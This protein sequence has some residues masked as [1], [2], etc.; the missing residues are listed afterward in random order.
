MAPE[1]V[2]SAR[3]VDRRADVW[4][5]G[6]CLYEMA[7]GQ[8]PFRADNLLDLGAKIVHEPEADVQSIRPDMPA[9]LA[10]IIHRCLQKKPDHRYADAGALAAALEEYAHRPA[11]DPRL[12]QHPFGHSGATAPFAGAPTSAPIPMNAP[13]PYGPAPF[14][15]PSSTRV[16]VDAPRS[17]PARA[18]D[19]GG[20]HGTG[21]AWGE[22]RPKAPSRVVPIVLAVF[23]LVALVGLVLVG[24]VF[25]RGKPSNEPPALAA[26]APPAAP[27]AAPPPATS[28]ETPPAEPPV[29]ASVIASATATTAPIAAAPLAPA[30][31]ASATHTRPAAAPVPPRPSASPSPSPR[32]A[33]SQR[34]FD[35]L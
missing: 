16:L 1:Q 3:T 9:E 32:P 26:S 31:I 8:A 29:I 4:S 21:I 25:V 10:A 28:T 12:G 34:A 17:T 20:A 30:P 23:G 27:P 22:T 6:A 18:E 33:A 24:V 5:L 35:H 7:T 15:P 11:S 19:T 2:T 14:A 13:A